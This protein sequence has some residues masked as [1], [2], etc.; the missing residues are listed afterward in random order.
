[1]AAP[2]ADTIAKNHT[3]IHGAAGGFGLSQIADLAVVLTATVTGTVADPLRL[4]DAGLTVQVAS[5]GAP[6]Q[7][8]PTVPERP[9]WGVMLSL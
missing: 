4:R 7:A 9:A 2:T 8:K 1:M 6:L 5:S 3:H